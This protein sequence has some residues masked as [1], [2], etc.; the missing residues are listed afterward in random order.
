MRK[1]IAF[2]V[3]C[4]L[5]FLLGCSPKQNV[6][7]DYILDHTKDT[8]VLMGSLTLD[9]SK[10]I[11]GTWAT[12]YPEN[13]KPKPFDRIE[14]CICNI[15][16]DT[17]KGNLFAL[18]IPVGNYKIDH[19]AVFNAASQTITPAES[20]PPLEFTVTKGEVT[21]VGNIHFHL[22]VRKLLWVKYGGD[23]VPRGKI[24]VTTSVFARLG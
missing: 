15:T 11:R 22:S 4:I 10:A 5:F 9:Y 24:S 6:K 23:P 16:E 20:P 3:F 8:G 13:S 21:Y 7:P 19:W 17:Y 1:S 18:E 14:A 2:S 12:I